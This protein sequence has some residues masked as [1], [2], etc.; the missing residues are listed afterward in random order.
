MPQILA[1]NEPFQEVRSHIAALTYQIE[2]AS[3]ESSKNSLRKEIEEIKAEVHKIYA[4][5]PDG[6][7][8]STM[9]LHARWKRELNA[10]KDEEGASCCRS[11]SS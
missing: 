7:H 11:A 6:R 1:L 8:R 5:R 9:T 3:S 4:A 10:W 2:V